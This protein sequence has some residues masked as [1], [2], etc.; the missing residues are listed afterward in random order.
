M[1]RSC[2]NSGLRTDHLLIVDEDAARCLEIFV[3]AVLPEDGLHVGL[4]RVLPKLRIGVAL[5]EQG[6]QG[7]LLER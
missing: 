1:G 5:G 6:A 2:C 7:T 3:F 4:L